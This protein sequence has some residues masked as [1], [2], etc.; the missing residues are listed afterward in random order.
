[1]SIE[2]KDHSKEFL[3]A[4]EKAIKNGLTA[5]GMTAEGHAKREI[6]KKVYSRGKVD[7]SYRLTGRLRNS[8]TY[9][10][11]GDKAA[12]STYSDDDG[13]TFSYDGTAPNDKDKAVYIGSNVEYAPYVELGTVKM[14]PRPYLRPAAT[15]HKAEYEA[16]MKAAM[17]NA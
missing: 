14:P 13:N 15:D 12:A 10:I 16:L 11:S 3:D 4:M 5:I 17:E 9:A 1:M 2:I 7:K 8:I 6:T